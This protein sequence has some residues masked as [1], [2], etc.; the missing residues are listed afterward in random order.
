[1]HQV[2]ERLALH[3][4]CGHRLL[5]G[6]Q[7]VLAAVHPWKIVGSLLRIVRE[8]VAAGFDFPQLLCFILLDVSHVF[9]ETSGPAVA[10][11]RCAPWDR[12]SS[13]IAGL[14]ASFKHEGWWCA[15]VSDCHHVAKRRNFIFMILKRPVWA[16]K[17]FQISFIRRWLL[18]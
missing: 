7:W 15:D 10:L 16:T 2:L 9:G 4:F 3:D 17:S 14:D 5:A 12:C 13:A 8:V 11:V 1:M 6:R 18:N